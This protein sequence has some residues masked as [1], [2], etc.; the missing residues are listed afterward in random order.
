[1][2]EKNYFKSHGITPSQFSEIL[3]RTPNLKGCSD[4]ILG[5][6][7][8][9]KAHLERLKDVTEIKKIP[10]S[11]PKQGDW[12]FKYKGI[13][14]TIESKTI[15]KDGLK[16]IG[17][18]FTGICRPRK[19]SYRHVTLQSGQQ[20]Y[21]DC[22]TVGEFD[23]LA[24]DMHAGLGIHKCVF[25]LNRNL[26]HVDSIRYSD[27]EKLLFLKT[28]VRISFP[29]PD[30]SIWTTSLKEVLEQLYKERTNLQLE[31]FK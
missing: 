30:N 5:E 29:L 31:L 20:R 19:R 10:D 2:A 12:E 17:D 25:T 4:G 15:V 22:L 7:L 27:E 26:P 8:G 21:T 18:G 16:K 23:I 1:M 9:V 24:V 13:P 28:R 11:D 3:S 6:E 14:L